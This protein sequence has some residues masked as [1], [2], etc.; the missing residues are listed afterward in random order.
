MCAVARLSPPDGFGADTSR[1]LARV[2]ARVDSPHILVLLPFQACAE[3]VTATLRQA[4]ISRVRS[5]RLAGAAPL[6]DIGCDGRCCHAA[7]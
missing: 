7:E 1:A 2:H 6:I 4:S 5:L 3:V